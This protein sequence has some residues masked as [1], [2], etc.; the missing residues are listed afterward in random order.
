MGSRGGVLGPGQ[1]AALS[2]QEDVAALM[3]AADTAEGMDAEGRFEWVGNFL[4][5]GTARRSPAHENWAKRREDAGGITR[6][7]PS[8]ELLESV[9]SS[10]QEMMARDSCRW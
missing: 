1:A 10:I 4:K 9:S 5:S 2:F 3:T 8:T 7:D 6:V